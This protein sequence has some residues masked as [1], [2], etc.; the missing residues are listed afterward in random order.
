M[1]HSA[2]IR[3]AQIPLF[4]SAPTLPPT[5][6]LF[7]PEIDRTQLWAAL[8][9]PSLALEV[10]RLSSA[11]SAWCVVHEHG[12][13]QRVY[14]VSDIAAQLG[15][16]QGMPLTAA[17]ALC[18]ELETEWRDEVTER[19]VLKQLADWANQYSSIVSLD[20]QALLIEVGGGLNLFGGLDTLW[21]RIRQDGEV[22]G[23]EMQLAIAP[24]PQAALLLAQCGVETQVQQPGDLKSVLG[25][26]PLNVL[27][28]TAKQCALF[29]RLGLQQLRDLW[30]LPS[31]GLI[32]R[33][34]T[35]FVD[36][37]DRLLGDKP[38]PRIRHQ[39]PPVFSAAW[40]FPME[41]DKLPFI[42]HALEQLVPR[43]VQFMRL[44]GLAVNQLQVRFF[45]A[46]RESSLIELGM[47]QMSCDAGHILDL[48]HECLEKTPLLAPV[49][50]LELC[51]AQFFE[52]TS[53][54]GNL[55]GDAQEQQGE[56]LQLLNQLEV[57]L[58]GEAVKHL[59]SKP[60]HRPEKA[61]GYGLSTV[62]MAMEHRPAWLLVQPQLLVNNLCDIHLISEPERIEG[63]WWDEQDVRR[64]YY[65]AIDGTGRRLWVFQDLNSQQWYLHGLF[66]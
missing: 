56:W 59:Q 34:G 40:V 66:G 44:R 48:L 1:R 63:G 7:N 12:G 65:R 38:E 50:E 41:T 43:L 64:D 23:Y 16:E 2:A 32:K 62:A 36:Y 46:Q 25:R 17:Y 18:P 27:P 42:Y 61:W 53:N 55:F 49:V 21:Q 24:T 5:E 9:F 11:D 39:S 13:Q 8:Y 22:R 10:L 20:Q 26:L 28:V 19:T 15:I 29:N 4:D 33:F 14:G 57:R 37:L 54:N 3:S 60:D 35:G 31:E 6:P 51:A 47:Q 58:G 30:R 45:Y 52:Q